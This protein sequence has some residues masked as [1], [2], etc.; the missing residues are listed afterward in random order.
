MG[1]RILF[2]LLVGIFFLD[3]LPLSMAADVHHY[4]FILKETNFTRLCF[5]KPMLTVNESFPGPTMHVRKGDTA[6]INVHNDGK[7]GI[8]I[9]WGLNDTFDD[10]FPNQPPVFFNFT[11][12]EADD[13]ILPEVGTK[14]RLINYGG[15]S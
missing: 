14:V 8:T 10:D 7:Y 4:S 15:I 11:G 5:T 12:D 9:H 3:G 2:L 1:C 6:F 13:Y